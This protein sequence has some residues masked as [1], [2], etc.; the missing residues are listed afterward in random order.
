M[1]SRRQRLHLDE[2]AAGGE[3]Y[4]NITENKER[5]PYNLT[6]KKCDI[7]VAGYETSGYGFVAHDN[8]KHGISMIDQSWF[9][10]KMGDRRDII[11]IMFQ[12]SGY[13]K[14][15]DCY[16]YIRHDLMDPKRSGI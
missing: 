12:E 4:I 15:Q 6:P 3:Y 9:R 2:S 11:Q 14:T 1:D 10:K 5:S 8:A 13:D 16:G 7:L